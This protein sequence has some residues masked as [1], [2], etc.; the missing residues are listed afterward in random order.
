MG[1]IGS[2]NNRKF[3]SDGHDPTTGASTTGEC[4]S[5]DKDPQRNKDETKTRH[6][7]VDGLTAERGVRKAPQDADACTDQSQPLKDDDDRGDMHWLRAWAW[8]REH[9]PDK[10]RFHRPYLY[11]LNSMA[12]FLEGKESERKV[13]GE[14]LSIEQAPFNA[15]GFASTVWDSS[16]VASKYLERYPFLVK[17]RKCLDL[18][19]GC[20]LVA[21]VM[22]SL[23]QRQL[24]ATDGHSHVTTKEGTA[25]ENEEANDEGSAVVATDLA[26]NLR[27][28]ERNCAQIGE[29]SRSFLRMCGLL[30]RMAEVADIPQDI[31]PRFR[32]HGMHRNMCRHSCRQV[33]E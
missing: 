6:L 31:E 33:A 22:G 1:S 12:P 17:G 20:G 24:L 15:E 11:P 32:E 26:S 28:L 2:S 27:L 18:S 4:E 10:A 9:R 3:S 25:E 16:I 30:A 14:K 19:A 29:R 7:K 8:K 5:K 13:P 21:V 23:Q